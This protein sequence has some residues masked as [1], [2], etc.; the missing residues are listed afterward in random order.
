MSVVLQYFAEAS[1]PLWLFFAYDREA[2][3]LTVLLLLSLLPFLFFPPSCSG[4]SS[5]SR[6]G[7]RS[8]GLTPVGMLHAM[9]ECV[10]RRRNSPSPCNDSPLL[11]F[12]SW[13]FGV[14]GRSRKG[15]DVELD[16]VLSASAAI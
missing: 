4:E 1:C 9:Y 14:V 8:A 5:R 2:E 3:L 11:V 13:F 12:L 10:G 6:R 15:V 16:R 7:N